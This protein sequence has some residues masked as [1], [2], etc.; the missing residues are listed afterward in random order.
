MVFLPYQPRENLSFTLS[1]FDVGVVTMKPAMQGLMFPAKLYGL[2]ATGRPVI[3][4]GMVGIETEA[5]L[6]RWRVGFLCQAGDVDGVV[7]AIRRLAQD[8]ELRS[9]FSR[10]ARECYE[11]DY[12]REIALANFED[13][14]AFF[15]ATKGQ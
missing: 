4:I 6:D 15:H 10:N 9:I 14:L 12:N 5:M 13:A 2:L 7:L 8:G 3:A 11:T 1:A